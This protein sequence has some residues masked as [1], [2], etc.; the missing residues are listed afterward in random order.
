MKAWKVCE[1]RIAEELGGRRVPVSGRQLG[2]APDIEHPTLSIEVKSRKRLPEWIKEA[3]EQA[4]AS[5]EQPQ[6]SISVLH[7]DGARYGKALVVMRLADFKRRLWC[8]CVQ[9]RREA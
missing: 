2:H 6:L 3:M 5:A 1:R 9:Q 7:E 4:E 8:E